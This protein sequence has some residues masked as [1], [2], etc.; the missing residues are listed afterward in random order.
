MLSVGFRMGD[1]SYTVATVMGRVVGV[2]RLPDGWVGM[3]YDDAVALYDRRRKEQEA[4]RRECELRHVRLDAL[5]RIRSADDLMPEF[6]GVRSGGS[7][8]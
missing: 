6:D 3:T 8:V 1:K 2:C 4:E 5:R 7:D